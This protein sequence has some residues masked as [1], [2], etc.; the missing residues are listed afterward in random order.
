MS[1][2]R[3]APRGGAVEDVLLLLANGYRR[4]GDRWNPCEFRQ[5][6]QPIEESPYLKCARAGVSVDRLG[7]CDKWQRRR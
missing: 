2:Q 5:F 4:A 7:T 1:A 6:S 3:Q